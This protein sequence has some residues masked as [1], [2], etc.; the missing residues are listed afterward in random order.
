MITHIIKPKESISSIARLYNVSKDE[1]FRLNNLNERTIL[2][3]GQ[4]IVISVNGKAAPAPKIVETKPT[5][6]IPATIPSNK[7]QH[8]VVAGDNL[9]RIAKQYQ[10]SEKQ[11][12]DWNGLKNDIIKVGAYLV[13]A[14][15]ANITAGQNT[16]KSEIKPIQ[17]D[18]KTAKIETPIKKAEPPVVIAQTVK[19]VIIEKPIE[20]ENKPDPAAPPTATI[21]KKGSDFFESQYSTSQN[22]IEGLSGTFKT[23]AGWQDKKY[24]VLL[25]GAQSGSVVKVSANNKTIYAKV[26]GPLPNIKEDNNLT[27]RVS[28]A[29]AAALGIVDNKFNAKVEY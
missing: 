4:K 5:N 18:V 13:V 3:I 6:T 1:L 14:G 8:L 22:T 24:Y 17:E 16:A 9:S 21:N 26:L 27:L 2:H 19:P 12:K 20:K 11:L 23:I 25:N 29:A 15:S 10:V 28:N 7:T